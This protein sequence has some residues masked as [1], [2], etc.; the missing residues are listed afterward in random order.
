MAEAHIPQTT[1]IK[2][3]GGQ[4]RCV[5]ASTEG[6]SWICLREQKVICYCGFK[7]KKMK[8]NIKKLK[9]LLLRQRLQMY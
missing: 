6:F 1:K 8:Q 5:S 3:E 7:K 9:E 4:G 2:V